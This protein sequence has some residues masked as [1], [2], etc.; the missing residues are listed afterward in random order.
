MGLGEGGSADP[1]IAPRLATL[2]LGKIKN[3][4]SDFAASSTDEKKNNKESVS[5][6]HTTTTTT[7]TTQEIESQEKEQLL[8]PKRRPPA[9]PSLLMNPTFFNNPRIRETSMPAANGHFS[10]R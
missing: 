1:D 8:K 5:A 3:L 9:A 2:V 7:T 6:E 10:A 4:K